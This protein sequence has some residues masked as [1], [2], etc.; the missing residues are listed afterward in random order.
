MG[1]LETCGMVIR[2]WFDVFDGAI[3][4]I[5]YIEKRLEEEDIPTQFHVPTAMNPD[6]SAH[7]FDRKGE[8]QADLKRAKE[9]VNEACQIAQNTMGEI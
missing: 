3:A 1:V 9:M 2:G 4:V 8:M 7:I 6:M 5:E